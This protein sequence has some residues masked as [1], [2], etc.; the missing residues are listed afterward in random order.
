MD[1]CWHRRD[2]RVA[3]NRALAVCDDALPVFVFDE[4]VLE[5]AA[6][7][8]VAFMLDAL[9]SLREEYRERGG[10]LLVERA[11]LRP[12]PPTSPPR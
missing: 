12:S 9:E 5:H 11:I 2:L 6:P 7:P 8:R 3:D 10:D 4:T 1:L